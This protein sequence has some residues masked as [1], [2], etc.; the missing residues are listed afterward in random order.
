LLTPKAKVGVA[1]RNR[2]AVAVAVAAAVMAAVAKVAAVVAKVAAA[3]AKVAAA[4]ARVAAAKAVA[5]AARVAAMLVLMQEAT[6][7]PEA[8]DALQTQVDGQKVPAAA[9][10]I[11]IAQNGRVHRAVP[12]VG[13]RHLMRVVEVSYLATS[14]SSCV[15]S[16]AFQS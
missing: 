8:V 7:Q 14:T 3:V 6:A 11:L 4:V 13:V 1:V 12:P 15:T 5:V 9:M 10:Q 16:K 2:R